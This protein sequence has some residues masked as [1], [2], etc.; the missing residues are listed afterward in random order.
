MATTLS[1]TEISQFLKE[2]QEKVE[3]LDE[4]IQRTP[5]TKN[6]IKSNFYANFVL[7]HI[8]VNIRNSYQDG[9][10]LS[11]GLIK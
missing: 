3:I 9:I 6:T 11:Q 4:Y 7:L 1:L 8:F 2:Q 10:F 5:F